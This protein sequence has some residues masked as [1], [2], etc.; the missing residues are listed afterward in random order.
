MGGQAMRRA[1]MEITHEADELAIMGLAEVAGSLRK[2]LET[3]RSL[4]DSLVARR[5]R[6]VILVDF[7][8]F[9]LR[10]ARAAHRRGV[11]VIYFISP[12]LWAW[13]PGRVRILARTVDR[14]V[15]ILPFEVTFYHR[16]GARAVYVGHPLV[17]QSRRA[18]RR[19]AARRRLGL[20]GD[21][22]ALALLPGSRR[23]E[24]RAMLP[25]MLE[26]AR[27][28]GHDPGLGRVLL[29][30]ASSLS[31]EDLRGAAGGSRA[32]EGVA[33][34]ADRFFDVLAAADVALVASGTA[35]LAAALSGT[36]MV[37]GYRLHPATFVLGRYL[38]RV[39]HVALVNLVAGYRVVPERLQDDFTAENLAREIRRLVRDPRAAREQRSAFRRVAER[40]GPPGALERAAQ[41]VLGGIGAAGNRSAPVRTAGALDGPIDGPQ[42]PLS[43]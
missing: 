1:G 14:I 36:P 3:Y 29:P 10:L 35:T 23:Q 4:R 28:L 30:V 7:P 42:T 5:P 27:R 6:A 20:T 11:P 21:Q 38:T 26:A 41:A 43:V 17:D 39:E 13:R 32:L 25:T 8:E 16:H 34:V 37:V 24:A 12:Q 40:L 9:N 2:A 22:R 19:D 15:C 31:L 18:P 33:L